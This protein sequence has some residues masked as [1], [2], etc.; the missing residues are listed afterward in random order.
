MGAAIWGRPY[1]GGHM[2]VAIWGRPYR[3]GHIVTH[4]GAAIWGRPYRD[5]HMGI[6]ID[7]NIFATGGKSPRRQRA[8]VDGAMVRG[9]SVNHSSTEQAKKCLAI[10]LGAFLRETRSLPCCAM[11]AAAT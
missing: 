3:G 6:K 5:G 2:G 4:M 10:C 7:P 8:R 9:L 11:V 1:G